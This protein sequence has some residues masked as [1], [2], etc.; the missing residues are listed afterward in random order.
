[1]CSW[2]LI[3]IPFPFLKLFECRLGNFFFNV[4]FPNAHDDAIWKELRGNW[5]IFSAGHL[6]IIM[7]NEKHEM[8]RSDKTL[9]SINVHIELV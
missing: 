6:I 2:I 5:S 3:F 7:V 9:T 1:M 4:N 8:R